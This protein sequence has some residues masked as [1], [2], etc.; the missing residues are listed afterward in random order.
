MTAADPP[1]SGP[2]LLRCEHLTVRRGKRDVVSD[3]SAELR[4]GEIVALLGPNG[5]GKSTLL[6]A[7]AGALPAAAGRVERHGRVGVR[8]SRPT[9]RAGPC[10]RT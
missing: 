4:A 9:W 7:L 2:V 8:S 10:S 6:D 5:A 1:E 3:V